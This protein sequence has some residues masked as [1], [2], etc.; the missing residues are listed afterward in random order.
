MI[1][2]VA[3]RRFAWLLRQRGYLFWTEDRLEEVMAVRGK[4]PDFYVRTASFGDLIAEVESFEEPT[5]LDRKAMAGSRSGFINPKPLLGRMKNAI[6]RAADQ[7]KP[8]AED[9]LPLLVVLDNWRRVGLPLEE[10]DLIQV[11]GDLIFV[12]TF[13]PVKGRA[14]DRRWEHG[15]GRQLGPK[16]RTYVSAVVVNIPKNPYVPEDPRLERP[17]RVRILH[18]PFA[19]I[20]LPRNIFADREDGREYERRLDRI[21]DQLVMAHTSARALEAILAFPAD[22]LFAPDET[23]FLRLV[24][25]NFS[26]QSALV[27]ANAFLDRD[28]NSITFR[29]LRR[30]LVRKSKPA[31]RPIVVRCMRLLFGSMAGRS[32]LPRARRLRG[33]VLAHLD[34]RFAFNPEWRRKAAVSAVEMQQL[35]KECGLERASSPGGASRSLED[36]QSRLHSTGAANVQSLAP[37]GQDAADPI[38]VSPSVGPAVRPSPDWV[39][40]DRRL[41]S[42]VS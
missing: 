27:L 18:N 17:M 9:G 10:T 32:V 36:H 16:Y 5:L 40:I 11:F 19:T 13:D 30:F 28:P 29:S 25:W 41:Q 24:I 6:R 31:A 14:T 1:P 4:R 20:S 12:A 2:N 39:V 33:K 15:R 21:W 35:L 38:P 3:E 37:K 34:R 42:L 23:M 22:P 26:R 7:L 8:Y